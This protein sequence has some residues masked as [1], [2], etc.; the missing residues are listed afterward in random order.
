MSGPD[1]DVTVERVVAGGDGLGHE[2]SGRVVFVPG[3]LPG[4]RVR[5]RAHDERKGFARAELIEVID[6]SPARIAPPCPFVAAGCGG[7]TWQ[8]VAPVA[9]QTLKAGIVADALSHIAKIDP[10]RIDPGPELD[11]FG[12]R[13]TLRV[14]VRDG[15]AGFR[16][17]A[18]HDIVTVEGCMVAHPLLDELIRYGR[19]GGA[20]EAT[21]RAGAATGERLALLDT[22]PDD[23][24]NLPADVVV[25]GPRGRGAVHEVV[26]GRTWRIGARSFFQSR[27][28]GADALVSVVRETL[29]GQIGAEDRL[30]DLYSGVGLLAGTVGSAAGSIVAV[31]GSAPASRDAKHNLRDLPA[32]VIRCDV[33]RWRPSPADVVVADPSRS[34]LGPRAVERISSTGASRVI[35]VSCDP[36][37]FARDAALLVAA[38]HSMVSV[39]L[40]D[41]F[42]HTPHVEIV[43]RFDS[44]G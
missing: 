3:A 39:T 11:P 21:L 12:Q 16:R 41:L 38:G 33:E 27:P 9:Q 17:R 18:S 44:V 25:V 29:G 40:V 20:S 30:V 1:L 14:A 4:E 42:P 28:D 43:S 5:A 37:A 35:L 36:A 26:A 6:P 32:V 2:P 24:V 22:E 31:E 13:T 34:G 15:R 19:F 7:C 10:P 23:E 8:H